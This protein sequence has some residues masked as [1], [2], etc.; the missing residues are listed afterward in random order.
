MGRVY[1]RVSTLE[2]ADA[3]RGAVAIGPGRSRLA[4]RLKGQRS[5][6][7]LLVAAGLVLLIVIVVGYLLLVAPG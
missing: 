7:P 2:A 5:K 6:T 3:A 4:M 1:H